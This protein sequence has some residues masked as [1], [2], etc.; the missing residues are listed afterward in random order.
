M[1]LWDAVYM[2]KKEIAKS[3]HYFV[4]CGL[5][6]KERNCQISSL[7][8]LWDAVFLE[9][10]DLLGTFHPFFTRILHC[11][12][13]GSSAFIIF[14]QKKSAIYIIDRVFRQFS[15]FSFLLFTLLLSLHSISSFSFRWFH[16]FV[17]LFCFFS[18]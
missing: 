14:I 17:S 3:P 18:Y 15:V 9:N 1:T 10:C 13:I 11:F 16:S 5:H 4:G 12:G 8:I 2:R 7:S 6:R